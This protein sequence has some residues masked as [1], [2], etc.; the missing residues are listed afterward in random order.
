MQPGA[1]RSLIKRDRS[2]IHWTMSGSSF[3]ILPPM[4]SALLVCERCA[5]SHHCQLRQS[6]SQ[7]SLSMITGDPS[8]RTNSPVGALVTCMTAGFSVA[9][10]T[11]RL[12][13]PTSRS[14]SGSLRVV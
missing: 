5:R 11:V 7:S 4:D 9:C 8:R 10:M 12:S 13:F 2:N 3:Y 1:E 6:V 14:P